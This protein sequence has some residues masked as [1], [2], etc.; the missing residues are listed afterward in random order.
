MEAKN[1]TKKTSAIKRREPTTATS[2]QK[3]GSA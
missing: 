2:L 3:S 1:T